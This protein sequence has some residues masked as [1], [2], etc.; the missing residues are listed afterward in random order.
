[1]KNII[2]KATLLVAI[3]Q[4]F[5]SCM[6]SRIVRPLD[7]G[8][9]AIGAHLGGPMIGFSGTTIPMPFTSIM[10]AQGV[11]DKTTVFGSLHTTSL[12]FGVIQT[13][14]GA[15][16]N[17][18]YSDSLKLGLSVTPAI[19]LAYD[20]WEGNFKAW[21]QLDVNVYWDIKP[22]KS[23]LYVGV[24]NWFELSSKKAHNQ[25]QTNRWIVNPQIG[26]TYVRKKWNYNIEGK[27]LTP[28]LNNEPGV[29]DYKGI[30]GK[31]AVGVY[32]SFT[33]KF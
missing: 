6:P 26:F 14:M 33:R 27:W 2:Y 1:M 16:Y 19:N 21:P 10:Y 4:F 31:G 29:V 24:D 22:K 18:V 20:K 8:Q 13:D 11:S 32:I 23:F 3:S 28:Y 5:Y 25:A 15:C 17:V 12:L 30:G 9:K 7:K